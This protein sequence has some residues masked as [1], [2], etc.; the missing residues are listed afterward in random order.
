MKRIFLS[1]LCFSSVFLIS[2]QQPDKTQ[3]VQKIDAYLQKIMSPDAPGGAVAIVSGDS[4]IYKKAF[5]KM[6]M[7]Y[8]LPNSNHTLFNLA[9]ISKHFTAYCI[10]LLEKDGKLNLDDDIHKYLP[11]LPRYKYKVTIRELIHHTSGIPSS[12]NLKLFAGVAFEAPWDADDEM[13]LIHRYSQLNYK[14]NNEGNYSNSG[15]FLLARIIEKVSGTGF[16]DFLT[17]NVFQPLGMHDSHVYDRPGKVFPGKATGYKKEDHD[18]IRMNTDGESVYGSTNLYTSLDD[19]TKW[20]QN[21]LKPANGDKSLA[22]KMFYPSDV[23]NFGDTINYTYGLNVRKYKGIKVADHGGYAMG[24]RSEIMYFPDDNVAMITMCNNESIDNWELLTGISDLYFNDRFT[25]V[26]SKQRKEIQVAGSLLKNYT[27]SYILPDG[28]R[29][30]FELAN[31]TLLLSIPGKSKYVMHP[32]S[33]KDF[34]VT[35]FNAQCSFEMGSNGQCDEII[36]NENN[37]RPVG[38]RTNETTALSDENLKRFSGNY[39]NDPLD[40]TY[41]VIFRNSRLYMVIPKTFHTYFGMKR[42]IPMYHVEKDKFYT[43]ELGLVEF[44]RDSG[45]NING[46]TIIDFGRVKHIDFRKEGR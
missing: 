16:T 13:D 11:D 41:P 42:E 33:E 31:D 18:Y 40:V 39:F 7:E 22:R 8:Q 26:K 37:G 27:G 1:L 20:M 9:S 2:A 24:F 6:S 34:F 35:E 46:F 10:L 4:V 3:L 12:D 32:E 17:Q 23:T 19:I 28:R 38:L 43:E 30:N 25:P 14:P 21:M 44:K 45:R 29:F 15:Y 36:W 5:G